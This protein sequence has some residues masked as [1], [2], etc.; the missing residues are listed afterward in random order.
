MENTELFIGYSHK[1]RL[2]KEKITTFLRLLERTE[3]V[4]FHT[5]SDSEIQLGENWENEIQNAIDE[6]KVALLLI[7]ADFLDSEFIMDTEVPRILK[8]AEDDQLVIIP[9]VVRPCPWE[10]FEWIRATQG[11]VDNNQ[12][13]SGQSEYHTELILTELVREISRM[14]TNS[15]ESTEADL[16]ATEGAP[17]IETLDT[18]WERPDRSGILIQNNFLT[19]AGVTNFV[20]NSTSH[21]DR[22]V[23]LLQIFR[24]QKQQT[25][26][27]VTETQ[28]YCILDDEKTAA[29]GRQ[30][31]WKMPLSETSPIQVKSRKE[32]KYTGLIDVGRKKNWLYSVKLHP[33]KGKLKDTLQ[34]MIE[35]AS[36]A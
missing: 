33:D 16:E 1:D 30:I 14:I 22:V 3:K 28:F 24:T 8:M 26:F 32:R 35:Y 10:L 11:Y 20:E 2:W 27:A 15:R 17:V 29:G 7:S 18:D 23:G 36:T 21:R 34:S 9:F 12:A 5:W 31:Q 25:W 4:N 6:A 13:L 19:N